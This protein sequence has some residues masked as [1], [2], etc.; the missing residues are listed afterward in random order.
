MKDKKTIFIL[1]FIITLITPLY[2]FYKTHTDLSGIK[3]NKFVLQK[4]NITWEVLEKRIKNKIIA[5][6][7]EVGIVIKDLSSARVILYEQ[8]KLFPS[9]SLVKIPIMAS[10]FYAVGNRKINLEEKI[11]LKT[12][13]KAPGSGLLKNMPV[14]REFTMRELIELMIAQS[15]NTAAN[16]L[17]ERLG[18]DYINDSFKKLGL[19]NTNL[20]RRMMDFR[21]RKEGVENYTTASDISYILEKIYRK[22]L[23]NKDI[24]RKCLELL[25][26]QKIRDRI[27]AMLP[28]NTTVAHKTGLERGICHDAGIVFTNNGDFLI[29]VLV[30]HKYKTANQ[31]K[32]FIARIAFLTYNYYQDE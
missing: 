26:D 2:F 32:K 6:K 21:N 31:S 12:T 5:F 7:G 28:A 17:I 14:G 9:A 20:S 30:K 23:L 25:K 15:D 10:C 27:P 11:S 4:R 18:Y 8:N 3:R 16:M 24:S 29:C 13:H 1:I 19:L 22:E